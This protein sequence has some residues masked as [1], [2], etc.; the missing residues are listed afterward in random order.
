MIVRMEGARRK[1]S[2]I[3]STVGALRCSERYRGHTRKFNP[4]RANQNVDYRMRLDWQLRGQDA[5]GDTHI[6]IFL[7]NIINQ[8]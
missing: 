6:F 2:C 8:I 3:S 5:V 1:G 7:I 4:K